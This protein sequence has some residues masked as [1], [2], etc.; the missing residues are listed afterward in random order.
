MFRFMDKG[1]ARGRSLDKSFAAFSRRWNGKSLKCDPK[2][3]FRLAPQTLRREY[4][5]WKAS[6]KITSALLLVYPS[7]GKLTHAQVAGVAAK[8]L[9]PGI[10]SFSAAFRGFPQPRATESAYRYAVG[11]PGRELTSRLFAARY[12][13]RRL[14]KKLRR[15][16]EELR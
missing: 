2:R 12:L 8:C 5:R 9:E 3:V 15:Y 7:V 16:V 14:E 4:Y 6:G 13:V 11:A 1:R 10:L